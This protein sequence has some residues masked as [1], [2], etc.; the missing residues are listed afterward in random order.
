MTLAQEIER[1]TDHLHFC[2]RVRDADP[3]YLPAYGKC[4]CG[5]EQ[6]RKRLGLYDELRQVVREWM[7]PVGVPI[8]GSMD[9]QNQYEEEV[10]A[11]CSKLLTSDAAQMLPRA[12]AEALVIIAFTLGVAWARDE[13]DMLELLKDHID[14]PQGG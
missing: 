10:L 13:P 7:Q 2:A 5:L 14:V 1:Y 9:E 11:H 6:I 3:P 8:G 4:T 12:Q